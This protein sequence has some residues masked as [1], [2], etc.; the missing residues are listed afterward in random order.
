MVAA[1]GGAEADQPVD[2]GGDEAD[3]AGAALQRIEFGLR[4]QPEVGVDPVER[5]QQRAIA[6]CRRHRRIGVGIEFELRLGPGQVGGDDRAHLRLGPFKLLGGQRAQVAAH[7][8]GGGDD[9]GLAGRFDPDPVGVELGGLPAA[10]QPD[11]IG[12]LVV[13][14][15][16][17]E[18]VDDP[19]QLVDRAIA[20]CRREH[21][22]R[23]AGGGARGD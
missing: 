7:H 10:D 2:I 9:V 4:R 3:V 13:G 8:C 11:I 22:A 17:A 16:A 6:R 15:L 23:V 21:P 12:Q 18:A 14:Q 5:G 19:R 1:A 20:R